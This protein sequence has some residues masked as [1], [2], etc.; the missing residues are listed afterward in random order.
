[1]ITLISKFPFF[2]I[3]K[4]KYNEIIINDNFRTEKQKELIKFIKGILSVDQVPINK[5]RFVFAP[6]FFYDIGNDKVNPIFQILLP[7]KYNSKKDR[8]II[9][10]GKSEKTIPIRFSEYVDID[11]NLIK[12]VLKHSKKGIVMYINENYFNG[13]VGIVNIDT[14][15]EYYNQT[16]EDYELIT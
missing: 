3:K 13:T 1:M 10:I 6:L 8:P 5:I 2:K 9:E 7:E 12:L 15:I 16:I 4:N 11:D 14:V